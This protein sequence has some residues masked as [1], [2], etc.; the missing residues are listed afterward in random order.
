MASIAQADVRSK[1]EAALTALTAA[2]F[3]DWITKPELWPHFLKVKDDP[4]ALRVVFLAVL[5]PV[6]TRALT[7]M[8]GLV[9]QLNHQLPGWTPADV[10]GMKLK[11]GHLHITP[12]AKGSTPVQVTLPTTFNVNFPADMVRVTVAPPQLNIAPG[13]IQAH[14]HLDQSRTDLEIEYQGDKLTRIRRS[15]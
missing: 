3:L 12:A 8:P 6:S 11:D 10:E 5:E 7:L 4:A 14:T 1:A 2:L 9:A 13:A 15:R